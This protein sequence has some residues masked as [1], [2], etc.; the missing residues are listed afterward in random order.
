MR[1]LPKNQGDRQTRRLADRLRLTVSTIFSAS[2]LSSFVLLA[3]LASANDFT[4][5]NKV[6]SQH[7]AGCHNA[8]DAEGDFSVSDFGSLMAGAGDESVVTPGNADDSLLM[9]LILG[10][11]E[12][13][14]P[15]EDEDQLNSS[16]I[17]VLRKWIEN[18]AL[19]PKSASMVTRPDVPELQ[20][21][22]QRFVTAAATSP[23]GQLAVAS[24]G[25]V[26]LLAPSSQQIWES[27]Q[28]PGKVNSLRFANGGESLV[29]GSGVTGVGG[30]VAII[31]T[32]SGEIMASSEGHS[33][34]IYCAALSR[35][36]RLL[37]TGSYDRKVILWK[38][39]GGSIELLHTF[40]SHNGAVYDLDFS[41][42]GQVLATAS[43]DATVKL[44]NTQ[45]FARLDTLGQP[46]GEM[47]C[48]RFSAD[49]NF[50]VAAGGDRQIRKWRVE[51]ET[52]PG[53]NPMVYARYAHGSAIVDL[54]LIGDS[55]IATSSDDRTV[56]VWNSDSL[57]IVGQPHEL[58]EVPTSVA[59]LGESQLVAIELT[60]KQH[61]FSVLPKPGDRT[62]TPKPDVRP[63]DV[64]T[65][66]LTEV[67]SSTLN[68]TKP[69]DEVEP[70]DEVSTATAIE[71]PARISGNIS[72]AGTGNG[73]VDLFTFEATAGSQWIFEVDV[74]K[75]SKLDSFV[76]IL[77]EDGNNV[78]RT[79]LQAIRESYFT[80][81]GKDSDIAD[82]FRL[83]KWE[84]MELDEFLYSSGEVTRLWLYPRG[85]DSGFKVYPGAGKRHTFFGTTPVSH[86]LG[87]TAYIVRPLLSDESPLPNGLPVF[88]IYFENDDD[89][90][91][92][93]GKDSRLTFTAPYTGKFTLLIR[94]ARQFGGEDF[95]YEIHARQPAPD[96]QLKFSDTDMELPIGGGREWSVTATRLDGLDGPIEVHLEGLP[97][98][99]EATNPVIIEAGQ[100]SAKG[101]IFLPARASGAL[102]TNTA[103]DAGSAAPT[104][105]SSKQGETD[106]PETSADKQEAKAP[107]VSIQLVA[108]ATVN[109]QEVT[110]ELD[111]TIKLS[112][113]EKPE[114]LMR[115]VS[116]NGD[117]DINQLTIAPG[118]T[119]MARLIIN[120]NGAKGPIS[121]GKDDAGRN[122][123]HGA[124]VD[125]IGLNGL[126]IPDGQTER[127]FFI[128]AAPKVRPGRRQFHL[129]TESSGKSTS[130]P[131]WLIVTE[132]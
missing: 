27:N 44:W 81:R 67:A 16:E 55:Y 111:Q 84:D 109:G 43:A 22:S 78:L 126:L 5:A 94:D 86:A 24:L 58:T 124:F 37:A 119:I 98:G 127:E 101:T 60:G 114:V 47:R 97:D 26:K 96:F 122:L 40:T 17:E 90:L 15:P 19:G 28:L 131:V 112:P 35:D 36:G 54:E 80:F 116:A 95:D 51:S 65:K 45:S 64:P 31:D 53:I 88:D 76:S 103:G 72:A 8:T 85:P 52:K 10:T 12:P 57:T 110:R 14:M 87:E 59:P 9:K 92:R 63:A 50:V 82:D 42:S 117:E 11:E 41:P 123:P 77:D 106:S 66:P 99:I 83:H 38:V 68:P 39:D 71:L 48:V 89:P 130:W 32:E 29:V 34:A 70:N 49:G 6:L 75:D 120:R 18:G 79:R 1:V 7:C 128:T 125:N 25:S 93:D 105:G 46:E 132:Q 118:E 4:A 108:K 61:R 2:L 62:G 107:A 56:K 30:L 102:A 23:K 129:R 121:F 13:K 69:F 74:P 91:R 20:P 33:D 73:E 100:Q 115:L 104:D 21:A 3:T 113:S